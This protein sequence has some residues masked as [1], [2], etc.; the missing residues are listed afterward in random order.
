MTNYTQSR[1][2]D[3]MV[4]AF[5]TPLD[6]PREM[7]RCTF[8][9]GGGK[10]VRSKYDEELP[11]WVSAALREIGFEEDR[12]A[13]LDFASQG[14]FKQQHDTGQ[15]LKT[16]IVFPR[17]T[18]ADT[19]SG[20]EAPEQKTGGFSTTS[21]EYIIA[22]CEFSTFQ[23]VVGTKAPSWTQK[24]KMLKSLQDVCEKFREVEAKLVR[25][26]ALSAEEQARYDSNSG[27]D[28]QKVTWLQ[29]EIKGMVEKGQI[30]P[31]EKSEV[32][33][34]IE[35]NIATLNSEIEKMKA[36]N[37]PKKVAAMEERL[38]VLVEKKKTIAAIT[39]LTHH[40]LRLGDEVLKLRM[41][42]LTF[43][44]LEEKQ[45]MGGL[46]L[47]ELK[48]LE[49]KFD[50]EANV[51]SLEQASRGWFDDDDDFKL[52]CEME[53]KAAKAKYAAKMKP[54]AK[55]KP[56]GSSSTA[57]K[58]AARGGGGIAWDTIGVKKKVAPV[59]K[60]KPAGFA[61]AFGGSDDGSDSDD[62]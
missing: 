6:A 31:K 37:K 60:A 24:K 15:N 28:E 30:T 54:A 14:T 1:A 47:A 39:P 29:S 62:N 10:L 51:A 36:D 27:Q 40:R 4:A 44:P 3:L 32:I 50:I 46:T 41:K 42:L 25:G 16:I 49:P 21:P 8:V 38:A 56:T 11:K 12:S 55:K 33:S 52:S 17:V 7:I 2:H 13:A 18:C 9:V 53:A 19:K 58:P 26:E 43:G 23:D 45:R 34:Q 59:A 61:A 35:A 20:G 57:A 22:A 48:Q 5:S